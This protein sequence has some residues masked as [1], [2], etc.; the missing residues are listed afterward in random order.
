MRAWGPVCLIALLGWACG[1]VVDETGP[2]IG[3]GSGTGGSGD[4]GTG[5]SGA[6]PH[7]DGGPYE[8]RDAAVDV[9]E[10]VQSDYTEPVC[11]DAAPN[12]V[13]LDC[14]LD[15]PHADCPRG[16]AC[17]P[18]VVYPDSADNC[19]QEQYGTV[20]APEGDGVQGDACT[21]GSCA[22]GYACVLTGQ[23]TQCVQLCDVY[24]PDTC[25]PGFLCLP[26][27]V[28]PGVGGCY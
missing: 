14:D 15:D 24:G 13:R 19:A 27:D 11:P 23:G 1:G 10:D 16:Y 2:G 7:R 4:D 12:P 5:G 28:Q 17:Y 6:W 25:P 22:G 3:V 21:G 18:Y 9:A 8:P 20:C 26:I